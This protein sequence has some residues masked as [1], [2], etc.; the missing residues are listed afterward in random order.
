MQFDAVLTAIKSAIK[1]QSNMSIIVRS[2]KFSAYYT[3]FRYAGQAYNR[4]TGFDR[5][6]KYQGLPAIDPA[7]LKLVGYKHALAFEKRLKSLLA[8]NRLGEAN[9]T[10]FRGAHLT[11]G[12]I[13]EAW[14]DY[15]EQA[16]AAGRMKGSTIRAA[17][18]ALRRVVNEVHP[19][20]R[21]KIHADKVDRGLVL[22]F[23]DARLSAAGDPESQERVKTSINSTVRQARQ[24]FARRARD[25][26]ARAGLEI[27]SSVEGFLAAS[28]LREP[29]G[30]FRGIEREQLQKL[31]KLAESLSETQ[32]DLFR[33]YLLV[34]CLGLR[35]GEILAAKWGWLETTPEG[36]AVLAIRPREDY[37][38]KTSREVPIH[39]ETLERLVRGAGESDPDEYIIL[40]EDTRRRAGGPAHSL[41]YR[42][43]SALVRP[44]VHDAATKTTYELRKLAGSTILTETDKIEAAAAFL[45]NSPEVARKN[46]ARFLGSVPG[47]S[48]GR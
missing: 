21:E 41:L 9:A 12:E 16:K 15:G 40:R 36:L 34:R 1:A 38:P 31:D 10:K 26:Y 33:A 22:D 18:L 32:V 11:L 30:G 24:V 47:I 5:P 23:Q 8:E 17:E 4:K 19:G 25:H 3:Y 2:P 35:T 44:H 37:R 14:R 13:L 46:Y 29:R 6:Q 27:P 20:D 48:L 28:F 42:A 43:L 7:E 45:G 39:L